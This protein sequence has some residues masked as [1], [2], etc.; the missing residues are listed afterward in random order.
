MKNI[1]ITISDA[2][3]VKKLERIQ[4]TFRKGENVLTP[5]QN[6]R[7]MANWRKLKGMMKKEKEQRKVILSKIKAYRVEIRKLQRDKP[8]GYRNKARKYKV[9][10]NKLAM[11]W[12]NKPIYKSV[13]PKE[14][15][16]A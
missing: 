4:R 1:F 7:L 14:P 15:K 16:A 6:E 8:E 9:A 5:E 11:K 12:Y 10:V 13:L 3:I 2:A